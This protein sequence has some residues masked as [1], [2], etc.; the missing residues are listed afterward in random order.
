MTDPS[1]RLRYVLDGVT[2]PV[3]RWELIAGAEHYGA[4]AATLHTCGPCPHGG[5]ELDRRD[6]HHHRWPPPV[7][8]RPDAVRGRPGPSRYAEPH[9]G[10]GPPRRGLPVILEAPAS[11]VPRRVRLLIE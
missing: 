5:T 2:F 11:A 3:E 7:N 1:D 4:D 6:Q 8:T 9:T 10:C